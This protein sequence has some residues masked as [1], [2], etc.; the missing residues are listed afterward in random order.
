MERGEEANKALVSLQVPTVG[1][2]VRIL[3]TDRLPREADNWGEIVGFL[4]FLRERLVTLVGDWQEER[5][6]S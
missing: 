5:Q 3:G 2:R 4:S 6:L 1:S